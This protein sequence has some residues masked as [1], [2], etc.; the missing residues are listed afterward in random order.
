MAIA[1]V[2]KSYLTGKEMNFSFDEERGVIRFNF[3]LKGK[4]KQVAFFVRITKDSYT[5]YAI[6]SIG[7]DA[8]NSDVMSRMAEFICRA[9]YGL[10]NGNFEIDMEDGEIRYRTHV[11]CKG[12]VILTEEIVTNSFLIPMFMYERYSDGIVGIIF[13]NITAKEAVTRCEQ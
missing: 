11:D 3:T 13:N 7:A 8:G 5:V 2:V 9:N 6:S 4:I 1:N 10:R 12:G